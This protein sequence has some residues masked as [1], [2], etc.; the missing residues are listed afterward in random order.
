MSDIHMK[1][2]HDL[3]P[4]EVEARIEKLADRLGGTWCWEGTEAVCEEWDR[5]RFDF[6][7][8]RPHL[9]APAESQTARAI[10]LARHG[11]GDGLV[12]GIRRSGRPSPSP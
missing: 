4:Q 2:A 11:H 6:F 9:H 12:V 10:D 3:A 8:K 5:L 1:R 7:R